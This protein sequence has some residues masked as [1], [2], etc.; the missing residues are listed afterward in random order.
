MAAR[1]ALT[2]PRLDELPSP[3]STTTD[4]AVSA[5]GVTVSV[6]AWPT[7][8]LAGVVASVTDAVGVTVTSTVPEFAPTLAVTVAFLFVVSRTRAMPFASVVALV[9]LNVPAVV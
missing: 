4:G 5:A 1:A 9:S 6:T 8:G 7:V 2:I 3:Q